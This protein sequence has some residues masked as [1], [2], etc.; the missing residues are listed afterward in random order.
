MPQ[1][2]SEILEHPLIETTLEAA[3]TFKSTF[4]V[5]NVLGYSDISWG[6]TFTHL[7][8]ISCRYNH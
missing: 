8:L 3:L 4:I 6:T 5:V 2:F 7:P 1:E